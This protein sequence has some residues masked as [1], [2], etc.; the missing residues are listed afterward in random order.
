MRNSPED[1]FWKTP[2]QGSY[3]NVI[4]LVNKT[5]YSFCFCA[6]ETISIYFNM[7]KDA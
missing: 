7:N 3:F 4:P 1:R 5:L 6:Q 2:Q